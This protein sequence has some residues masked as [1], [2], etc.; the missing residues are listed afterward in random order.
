MSENY[1][2]IGL[3][4]GTSC[5]G[6]DIALCR[7]S[8]DGERWQFELLKTVT[9]AFPVSLQE[10]LL[11]A[12]NMNGLDLA[13]LDIDF[14]IWSGEKVSEFLTPDDPKPLFVASHGHTVF[15]R[16][17]KFLS[18][19]IGK[20]AAIASAC[21]LPVVFDFRPLDVLHGG[22]GAPLVPIG[23][24][25][26]F[27]QYSHCINLGG[28]ANIST[29]LGDRR[30]A[31]DIC[32]ANIVINQLA[33]QLGKEFDK[34]GKIGRSGKII[35]SLLV[36]LNAKN[37]YKLAAPKSLGKEWVD[38]EFQPLNKKYRDL[39]SIPDLIRTFYEH[40]AL[41]VVNAVDDEKA[42]VLLSGGGA[43]NTFLI[44]LFREKSKAEFIVPDSEIVSFKE[45]MVFSFMGLL[46][47][48]QKPNI[49]STATGAG[50]DVCSGLISLP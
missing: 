29:R 17:D 50:Q 47:W 2:C 33:S 9:R 49:L 27:P 45:A 39:A 19:Q 22:Q 21:A 15:H 31:Y 43:F 5:D 37:F 18:L 46:R 26:L 24:E 30:I 35:N 16:P 25:L 3:M 13:Q 14:G 38:L 12:P 41:Q 1:Y 40:I 23:D 6:L 28:F 10:S 11:N 48:L 36:E 8:R 7:F 34:D 44:E 32:P 20:G 42:K 4:S